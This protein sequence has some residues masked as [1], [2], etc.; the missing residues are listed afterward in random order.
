MVERLSKE[1]MYKY[2]FSFTFLQ[3]REKV[4]HF[5]NKVLMIIMM[6]KKEIENRKNEK[7]VKKKYFCPVCGST[8]IRPVKG[9]F[10]CLNCKAT[11]SEPKETE[12]EL[13][14]RPRYIG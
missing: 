10:K 14:K 8:A 13:R 3:L 6:R 5:L 12:V 9:R 7:I 11:F 1:E 2:S 4:N